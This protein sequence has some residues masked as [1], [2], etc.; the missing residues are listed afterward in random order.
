M[1][2]NYKEILK[3]LVSALSVFLIGAVIVSDIQKSVGII[4]LKTHIQIRYMSWDL[5]SMLGVDKSNYY[6][7]I[8]QHCFFWVV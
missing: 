3:I 1:K 8:Y 6:I 7:Y 4:S 5:Y 2:I